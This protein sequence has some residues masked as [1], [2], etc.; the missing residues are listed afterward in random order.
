M[1]ER[2]G[3]E[4]RGVV[5]GMSVPARFIIYDSRLSL[6]A[7]ARAAGMGR[8]AGATARSMAE[9]RP[10]LHQ[11]RGLILNPDGGSQYS[12]ARYRRLIADF[13]MVQSMSRRG[14]CRYRRAS[15]ARR[16]GQR[17]ARDGG[18]GLAFRTTGHVRIRIVGRAGTTGHDETEY[19]RLQ[20]ADQRQ[21]DEQM[22]GLP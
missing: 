14:N 5:L 15:R 13:A 17:D 19:P 22:G 8:Q 11:H 10:H 20:A 6:P 3:L 1:M 16:V 2:I 9:R 4:R 7:T 18:I 12:S 21:R